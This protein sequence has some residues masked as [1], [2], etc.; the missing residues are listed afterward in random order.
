MGYDLM[1]KSCKHGKSQCISDMLCNHQILDESYFS[2]NFN[3]FSEYWSVDMANGHSGRV[4]ALQ[5]R[6][7]IARMESENIGSDIPLNCDG[8]TPVIDVFHYHI[9]RLLKFVEGYPKMTFVGAQIQCFYPDDNDTDDTDNETDDDKPVST[10]IENDTNESVLYF[11]HPTKG[12]IVIDSYAKASDVFTI[13]SLT[14]DP[15]SKQWLEIARTMP[16]AP[17]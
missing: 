4:V 12:N 7:A 17:K 8:W 14:G 13:L 2:Y 3:C 10:C 16:D 6:D 9:K 1:M 11:L 5:L 15:R